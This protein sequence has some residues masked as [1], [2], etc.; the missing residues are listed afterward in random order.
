M[1]SNRLA[2]A[3]IVQTTEYAGGS[4][5]VTGWHAFDGLPIGVFPGLSPGTDLVVAID[6]VFEE[7]ADLAI[8][9]RVA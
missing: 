1:N 9:D 6:R 4:D 8:A 5:A 7:T 3:D 2:S